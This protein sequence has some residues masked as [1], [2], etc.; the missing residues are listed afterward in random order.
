MTDR[1]DPAAWLAAGG[2]ASA[3]LW[4]GVEVAGAVDWAE[5][6]LLATAAGLIAVA[7]HLAA[8]ITQR[9]MLALSVPLLVGWWIAAASAV[10]L[11]ATLLLAG[12]GGLLAGAAASVLAAGSPGRAAALTLGVALLVDRC[13]EVH[14]GSHALAVG[15]LA[16]VGPLAGAG[17]LTVAALALGWWAQ[18]GLA[19]AL[20]HHGRT[21]T[22]AAALGMAAAPYLALVGAYGGA[23]G[24]WAGALLAHADGGP[25]DV[26]SGLVLAAVALAAGGTMAATLALTT[27]VW[28]L[29]QLALRVRPDLVDLAP[30]LAG[31]AATAIV[32][33]GLRSARTES[34]DG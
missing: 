22:R 20:L 3:G 6:V 16:G 11:A 24:G 7:A 28:L 18:A 33:A 30:W 13:S 14:L 34:G 19:A 26:V 12:A 29:P 4:L 27:A 2:L 15:G 32:V 10:D 31:L 23:A 25:P 5:A 21:P 17:A 9:P 8:G 1:G